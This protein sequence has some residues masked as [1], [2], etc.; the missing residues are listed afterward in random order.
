MLSQFPL[1]HSLFVRFAHFSR[2]GQK[3]IANRG[4]IYSGH[5]FLAHIGCIPVSGIVRFMDFILGI[6]VLI[7]ATWL[8]FKLRPTQPYYRHDLEPKEGDI[9]IAGAKKI[10]KQALKEEGTPPFDGA[11]KSDINEN[12]KDE[13]DA[14]TELVKEENE[15]LFDEMKELEEEL[16]DAD[17]EDKEDLEKEIAEYKDKLKSKDTSNSLLWKLNQLRGIDTKT[18]SDLQKKNYKKS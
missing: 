14:F 18:N 9:P 12:I 17:E 2:G 13:I 6:L 4:Y 7:T 8:Y 15:V 5:A 16:E 11:T 10:L 3:P 1:K